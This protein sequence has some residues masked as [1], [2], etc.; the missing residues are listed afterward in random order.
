MRA[1]TVYL[2]QKTPALKLVVPLIAGI[3]FNW[4]IAPRL[5]HIVATVALLL[6]AGAAVHIVLFQKGYIFPV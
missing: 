2:W 5:Y 1:Y 3:V 6:L 4:Y